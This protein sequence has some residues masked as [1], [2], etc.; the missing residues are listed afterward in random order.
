MAMDERVL[1][2]GIAHD[3]TGQP[4]AELA[5]LSDAE[6]VDLLVGGYVYDV[7]AVGGRVY[8]V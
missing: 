5:A 6:L 3:M 7:A 8:E 1:L 2:E 4:A